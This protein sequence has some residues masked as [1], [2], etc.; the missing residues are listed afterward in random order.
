MPGKSGRLLWVSLLVALVLLP[1]VTLTR[2]PAG[3]RA[4][5]RGGFGVGPARV[6]DPGWRLRIPL[7]QVVHRYPADLLRIEGSGDFTSSEG[8]SLRLSYRFSA[9][10]DPDRLSDFDDKAR[11][12]AARVFLEETVRRTL[13]AWISGESASRWTAGEE[14]PATAAV[15]GEL[16]TLGLKEISLTLGRAGAPSEADRAAALAELRRKSRDTGR[17]ILIIG[18]DGADWQIIDPWIREGKLPVLARLK[19]SA[20]WAN[21]KS[22][23]PILSPL[24]WTTAAT[25]RSPEEHGIVDFLVRDTTTGQKVPISSRFRKVRAL[26]NIFSEMGRKVDVV[27]W[28]ASWPAEPVDGVVV[29]DRVSYS[30]FGY[31]TEAEKLPGATYPAEYI[32]EIRD[33]LITDADIT[34]DEVRKF[35]DVTA[36]EFQ[37]RRAQINGGNP[38]KAYADPVN[39]LTRV[40][41]STRNYQTITLDLLS[42]GQPDLMMIYFQ[43]IDEVSHRF[44]HMMPPRME[45][46][47]DDDYRR[48]HGAV[49]AFYRYQDRLLGEILERADPRSTVVILSDHGFKNGPGR[50]TDDPPYIEGKPGKW[51]R[52]YGIFLMAGPGIRPGPID[53]VSLLDVAPT[54]LALAGLPP[55]REMKG[56]VL[57]E[58]FQDEAA[59]ALPG[60]RVASYEVGPAAASE[61][62]GDTSAA[63]REMI[64]SLRALGYIG[65]GGGGGTEEGSAPGEPGEPGELSG[66]T[67]T[68]HSNLAWLH[69]KSKSYDK[70]QAE[71]DAALEMFP[72]YV[73]AL[74]TQASLYQATRKPEKAMEVYRRILDAGGSERGVMSGLAGLFEQTGRIDEGIAYFSWLR[75]ERPGEAEAAVGLGRLEEA[76]GNTARATVLY[77][78]AIRQ[79]PAGPEAAGRLYEI[80]KKRGE[81]TT[82]EPAIAR[83]LSLNENSVVHQNLMGLI[84]SRKGDWAGAE[85]HLRRAVELDPDYA[86]VLANL[87][88]LCARTGRSEEAIRILT[89]AVEKEPTNYE[90]RMNLGAALGKAGR[91]RDAIAQFEEARK[92]GFRSPTLYN[93]LAVAYHETGQFG[94]CIESLKESLALDP[95]QPEVRAMLSDAESQAS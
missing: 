38:K 19:A 28:W 54:V 50:P 66:D 31:K 37:E 45:M 48:F 16:S 85:R 3:S 17:K 36:V 62:V 13:S 87:G 24:L 18:L 44:A 23:Q 68:Y 15:A 14:R 33:R 57:S 11:G 67:V 30:L 83:A 20:A 7:L 92:R 46:V 73:P 72:E 22:M 80:L 32:S 25:G 71:L 41:A 89:R 77:R 69:L 61:A 64:E 84:L 8:V 94:K 60:E 91:H 59:R 93:G 21:L 95:N 9:R 63:D 56:R 51:H 27:A 47:S 43:G 53:T 40:L 75:K 82:L 2:V 88:S 29:S 79:E 5:L 55:S 42:R 49:E 90:A 52:L 10:I 58:A 34:L 6:L 78:E 26:W 4:V 12:R 65:G 86:G 35:A 1:L 81:E 74:L 39:H 76:K 70:A